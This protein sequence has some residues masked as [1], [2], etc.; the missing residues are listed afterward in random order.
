MAFSTKDKA[1]SAT[2]STS[3]NHATVNTSMNIHMYIWQINNVVT[4]ASF[5]QISDVPFRKLFVLRM[6]LVLTEPVIHKMKSTEFS[7][8]SRERKQWT[9][10]NA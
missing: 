8:I 6:Y 2:T 10:R 5:V 3:I 9:G 1:F 7:F 4:A